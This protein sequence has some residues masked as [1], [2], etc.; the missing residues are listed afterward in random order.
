[1]SPDL[2]RLNPNWIGDL[3][4]QYNR[5]SSVP[6][7]LSRASFAD[8][9]MCRALVKMFKIEPSSNYVPCSASKLLHGCKFWAENSQKSPSLDPPPYRG[10]KWSGGEH[11]ISASWGSVN[12]STSSGFT[13]STRILAMEQPPPLLGAYI[14]SGFT[15]STAECQ[16][17]EVDLHQCESRLSQLNA[18]HYNTIEG[19][20]HCGLPPPQ[21]M[22][23]KAAEH[24]NRPLSWYDH[25]QKRCLL[26]PYWRQSK[27]HCM[28]HMATLCH[29]AILP[30]AYTVRNPEDIG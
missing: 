19:L 22:P 3:H 12:S 30:A 11:F 17:N 8:I 10:M 25:S 9:T 21:W 28:S 6:P 7:Q 18:L 20:H 27:H 15:T 4:L 13:T 29:A 14:S 5:R 1:M 24:N 23:N 2:A 26:R 16:T